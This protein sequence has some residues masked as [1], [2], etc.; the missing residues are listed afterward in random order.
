[1]FWKRKNHIRFPA[2]FL[3]FAISNEQAAGDPMTQIVRLPTVLLLVYMSGVV[4]QAQ[5]PSTDAFLDVS[6]Q[7]KG[8]FIDDIQIHELIVKGEA[9]ARVASIENISELPLRIAVV[10]D[11]SE[12]QMPFARKNRELYA[13][14]IELLPLRTID[15]ACLISF[16]QDLNAVQGPTSDKTLL[17]KGMDSLKYRG[18]TKLSDAI[19][20]ASKAFHDQRGSRR[21]MIVLTD[22]EDTASGHK[23]KDVFNEA[24][25]NYVR[26]YMLIH[27]SKI[28]MSHQ[29]LDADYVGKTGGKVYSYYD[30]RA[31]SDGVMQI[32]DELTHLKRIRFSGMTAGQE[33]S[34]LKL[35]VSRKG[36]KAFYPSA[37][38]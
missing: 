32:L 18:P 6:F 30:Q 20:Y 35:S 5:T 16:N 26:I 14:L 2:P 23:L 38:K 28:A 9:K 11:T 3:E 25:V 8:A 31:A 19:I 10:V 15:S 4:L 7:Q 27:P 12:S 22:G 37:I 29:F 21:A 13:K 36:V 1:L 24:I 17:L 33:K 34:G